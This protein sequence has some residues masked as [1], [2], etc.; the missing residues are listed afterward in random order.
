MADD[1]VTRSKTR[2]VQKPENTPRPSQA[3]S[4]SGSTVSRSSLA[5]RR[6]VLQAQMEVAA[7][8]LEL[9]KLQEAE[10]EFQGQDDRASSPLL[11]KA[12]MDMAGDVEQPHGLQTTNEEKDQEGG[13]LGD[14]AH[15]GPQPEVPLEEVLRDTSL[16]D[17]RREH[18]LRELGYQN[19]LSRLHADVENW[20]REVDAC[21]REMSRLQEEKADERKTAKT[22]EAGLRRELQAS[23]QE[24]RD[25]QEEL[26]QLHGRLADSHGTNDRLQQQLSLLREELSMG[27]REIESSGRRAAEVPPQRIQSDLSDIMSEFAGA[28]RD[29]IAS[30]TEGASRAPEGGQSDLKQFAARQST[31]NTNLPAFSGRAEEWPAFI[32]IYKTTTMECGFTNAENANRLQ[33][34]LKGVAKEAVKLMLAVPDNVDLAIKTLEQRFG[35][36]ELVVE[37]LIAKAK[38]FRGI[39]ADDLD[40]LIHFTSAVNNVVVT[41]TQLECAGHLS[42][43]QLRRELVEKLPAHLKLQWGEHVGAGRLKA[44][45][46]DFAEWLTTR[47]EAAMLVT[48]PRTPKQGGGVSTMFADGKRPNSGCPNCHGQHGLAFC[49]DFKA[50]SRSK[51]WE[52]MRKLGLCGGCLRKGHWRRD[53]RSAKCEKCGEKHHTLLHQDQEKPSGRHSGQAVPSSSEKPTTMATSDAQPRNVSFLVLPVVL[54]SNG[55]SMVVNALLDSASSASYIREEIAEEL[56]L[57]GK[58]CD[59]NAAVVGGQTV[60]GRRRRVRA[61]IRSTDGQF[62][63]NLTAWAL[64]AI[65]R[66]EEVVNWE[67]LKDAYQHLQDVPVRNLPS[68][69]ID[70]LIGLD[71]VAAH[72]VLDERSGREGEPIARQLPLGWVCFGPT[73]TESVSFPRA[74][75]N[76][77]ISDNDA[78]RRLEQLVSNFWDTEAV[79]QTDQ[80]ATLTAAEQEAENL[81]SATMELKDDHI[82]TK[83]PWTNGHSP[84]VTESRS[85]AESRLDS[86]ERTLSRKPEVAKQY[87]EVLE[88]HLAKGYIV[89]CSGSDQQHQDQWFLPH[90]PVIR[91]DK[92]TTKVRVV[93][94]AAATVNGKSLNSEMHAG[95]KLQKDLTQVL[96]RFCK[97]PVALVADIAEM[98]LQVKLHPDDWRYVRFLWRRKPDEPP[99][100]FQFTRLVFGLK[101]SPYLACRAVRALTDAIKEDYN[102]AVVEAVR[103]SMY[104]DDLLGSVADVPEAVEVRCGVQ[105]LLDRGSLH[106]RKWR[107]NSSEVLASIP[108]EDRAKDAMV[109]LE[110]DKSGLAGVVKTLG[111]AWDARTD[112]FTFPYNPPEQSPRTKRKV[113]AKMAS[114]FDPRGQI[115]PFTIRA[116]NMFQDLCLQGLAWDE[117]LPD[118][119]QKRWKRWFSELPDLGRI[120]AQ[121]CFKDA[122]R[123]S[124]QAT[125]SVHTFTDASDHAVAAASYVRAEYPDGSV[126][127]TLAF[128]KARTAPIKKVTIPKLELRGAALGVKVSTVVGD[129]LNIPVKQH[130]FWTD[131]QNVL[132]WVRSHSRDFKID[133]ANKI[134]EIQAATDGGQW[135]HVPGKI[136]PADKGTRGMKALVLAED[137][138]WWG[139]PAFLQQTSTHWPATDLHPPRELPGKLKKTAVMTFVARDIANLTRH[140]TWRKA[141]RVQAWCSRFVC[142]LRRQITRGTQ[143]A[144]QQNGETAHVQVTVR[145]RNA[146]GKCIRVTQIDVPELSKEEVETAQ[147]HLIS[148]AQEE[149]YPATFHSLRAGKPTQPSDP[150]YKLTPEMFSKGGRQVIALGSRLAQSSHLPTGLQRPLILPPKHRV[151]RLIIEDEDRKCR[152]AVGPQHLL[153]RLRQNYWIVKGLPTVKTVRRECVACR[154]IWAKPMEQIMAPLPEYRTAGSLKPFSKSAVDFAGPFF[155]RQGRG[156]VQQKRYLCVFTCLETR[157]CHLEMANSLET[158]SFLLAFTRFTKRRG[159]PRLMVSDN[160]T[161][162]VGAEREMQEAM[163]RLDK[164]KLNASTTDIEW[165]F[166]PPRA[167]HFG[168]VFES[169]VKAAKRALMAIVGRANLTDEELRTAFVEAEDLLNSRPL[170]TVSSDPHDLEAL[171]PQHFLVGRLDTPTGLQAEVDSQDIV[172]PSRRWRMVQHLVKEVWRRWLTEFVPQLSLRQKWRQTK[173]DIK[174]GEIVL[175]LT[176]DTSRRHWPLGRI[177]E[178][179][180]AKDGHTRVVDVRVG[181][182]TYRRSIQHLV[183]LPQTAEQADLTRADQQQPS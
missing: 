67:E 12:V 92:E 20:Q 74:Y 62:S 36:P 58:L 77:E 140:S 98:F 32:N 169:M 48:G 23:K 88:N 90:F 155:T 49:P 10:A 100:V 122:N 6:A 53:C 157:A 24:L 158:D 175:V 126:K 163:E 5:R 143:T 68:G 42:N 104:V 132:Y 38:Q 107:S 41:M 19:Q 83:I 44:D 171:T 110:A 146:A 183:R 31:V 181:E 71:V 60:S 138:S 2:L 162:F 45:L 127:V 113:L 15:G 93:F 108:E 28:V 167:P 165:R 9:A 136:N 26:H 13:A 50:L 144:P 54:E 161:N 168:G 33:A 3:G 170:T 154:K 72:K 164:T 151:T 78:D 65:T 52:L 153:G 75:Q 145:R 156:K 1:R 118:G 46:K 8:T 80:K 7:V 179:F 176:P 16:V 166:N 85:M 134:S 30:G 129:A 82:I 139:G 40:S 69:S 35:R 17:E 43:P 27:T 177:A 123:P 106:L 34:A 120:K 73:P 149:E 18:Q 159:I 111:V 147:V 119:E 116:R 182:K 121:R 96:L 172:N 21:R 141:Y 94:D 51:R 125:L 11:R 105:D 150:L 148:T 81:V 37:E 130:T 56:K 97:E 174:V 59:F 66:D 86:L 4:E 95:P 25:A 117:P 57:P 115:S 180:P 29:A 70:L 76:E 89:K 135:R 109:S 102:G 124:S 61:G 39:R 55:R 91:Q 114:I 131:S 84:N 79:G 178:V 128:A 99:Q 64:P 112:H 103:D 47:A 160:G 142:N 101:A 152:H 173:E 22:V 63:A 14:G 133:V 137:Q 87:N